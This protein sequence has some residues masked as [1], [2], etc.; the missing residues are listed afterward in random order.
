MILIE[1]TPPVTSTEIQQKNDEFSKLWEFLQDERL[2]QLADRVRSLEFN[3]FVV[4]NEVMLHFGKVIHD[5]RNIDAVTDEVVV[6]EKASQGM[7]ADLRDSLRGMHNR[8]QKKENITGKKNL[9][10]EKF[11]ELSATFLIRFYTLLMEGNLPFPKVTELLNQFIQ[12]S[13]KSISQISEVLDLLNGKDEVSSEAQRKLKI[14]LDSFDRNLLDLEDV[15]TRIKPF[16][17]NDRIPEIHAENEEYYQEQYALYHELAP[18]SA[19]L[20]EHFKASEPGQLKTKKMHQQDFF[21]SR[22]NSSVDINTGMAVT[23]GLH[24]P[25]SV[26]MTEEARK[27]ATGIH[28]LVEL[29]FINPFNDNDPFYNA[30][31]GVDDGKPFN[32]DIIGEEGGFSFASMSFKDTPDTLLLLPDKVLDLL[33]PKELQDQMGDSK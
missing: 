29:G 5:M 3:D 15:I 11:D 26:A 30:I 24:S 22:T 10:K 25:T 20:S 2:V 27:S 32:F 21:Q 16:F 17:Y 4:V 6:L 18:R 12:E 13:K 1:A 7:F 33:T 28:S 31:H 19:I 23:D 14:Y 8:N 9:L